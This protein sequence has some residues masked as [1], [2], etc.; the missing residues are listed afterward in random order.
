MSPVL[1]ENLV[2]KTLGYADQV[3]TFAFQGGEPTLAGLDFY[4][5]LLDLQKKYNSKQVQIINTLQTNGTLITE[6]WAQ[7]L[8]ENRF[9]V[10]LS[11]DGPKEIHDYA[12]I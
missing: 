10:G 1:L 11:L 12:E 9:L 3:C 6:E 8:G 5:L 2:E 7:F 4:R